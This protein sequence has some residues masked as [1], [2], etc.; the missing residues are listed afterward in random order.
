MNPIKFSILSFFCSS[1]PEWHGRN[2]H[3]ENCRHGHGLN[4]RC[5]VAGA[6]VTAIDE[7]TN[8]TR[9]TVTSTAGNY[10]FESMVPGSYTIR[11]HAEGFKAF[12]SRANVLTIGQPMTVNARL[13]VGATNENVNVVASAEVVANQY[14]GG[15]GNLEDQVAVTD[16]PI[17]GDR[18]RNPLDLVNFQPASS[19]VT[20]AA[21]GFTCTVRAMAPG[22]TPWMGWMST[23][24]ALPAAT[25]L[26]SVRIRT[27]WRNSGL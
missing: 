14:L 10:S 16:L 4:R 21:K 3:V 22:L 23:K 1:L 6:R 20:T 18:G 17:I 9:T 15:F 13:D 12:N 25:L 11:V 5:F 19:S 7:A 26:P 27:C 8:I 24:P 2:R